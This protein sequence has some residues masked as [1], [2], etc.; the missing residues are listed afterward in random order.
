M[1]KR[2]FLDFHVFVREW[3]RTKKK[4]WTENTVSRGIL[5][6]KEEVD[7]G[8][9]LVWEREQYELFSSLKAMGLAT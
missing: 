8:E 3:K 2:I 7:Y 9:K 1:L 6:H 5:T 4:K